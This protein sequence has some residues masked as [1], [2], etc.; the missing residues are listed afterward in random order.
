MLVGMLKQGGDKRHGKS[1]FQTWK[2]HVGQGRVKEFISSA[3]SGQERWL[4]L[5]VC[6]CVLYLYLSADS[7]TT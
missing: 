5:H 3:Q 7:L 4:T 1:T 2:Q 6:V